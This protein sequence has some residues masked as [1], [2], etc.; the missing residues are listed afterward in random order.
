MVYA[1]VT[2]ISLIDST[3]LVMNTSDVHADIF[4]DPFPVAITLFALTMLYH[5]LA[6]ALV[7]VGVTPD[8]VVGDSAW[9]TVLATSGFGSKEV[10]FRG[11]G[12]CGARDDI[13]DIGCY[14]SANAVTLSGDETH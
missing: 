13:V 10:A 9:E 12:V 7:A 11:R 2:V 1:S 6:A 4:G 8:A 3:G 14:S 5:T